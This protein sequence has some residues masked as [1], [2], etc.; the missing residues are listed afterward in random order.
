MKAF[1][2]DT[3]LSEANRPPLLLRWL[4]AQFMLVGSRRYIPEKDLP[5]GTDWDFIGYDDG[6]TRVRLARIGFYSSELTFEYLDSSTTAIY[7]KKDQIGNDIAVQ[8]V[9]KRP[10]MMPAII[11][12]WLLMDKHPDIFKNYVWKKN[13]E[14]LERRRFFELFINHVGNELK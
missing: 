10:E 7:K 9:L 11:K 4:S 8:V 12:T 3:F 1:D 6:P 13:V 14:L 5:E 2:P